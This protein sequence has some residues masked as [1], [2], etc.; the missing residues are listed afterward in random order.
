MAMVDPL[1]DLDLPEKALTDIALSLREIHETC[2]WSPEKLARMAGLPVE[3][4]RA[5]EAGAP[6]LQPPVK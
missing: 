1:A 6:S 4:I 3:R 2:G 5:Y